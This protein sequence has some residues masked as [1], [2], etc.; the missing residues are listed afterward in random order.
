MVLTQLVRLFDRFDKINYRLRFYGTIDRCLSLNLGY[1]CNS[2][3]LLCRAFLRTFRICIAPSWRKWEDGRYSIFLSSSWVDVT[4]TTGPILLK[5][6]RATK[7]TVFW[8]CFRDFVGAQ[9]IEYLSES[10]HF[11]AEVF[12]I[13]SRFVLAKINFGGLVHLDS[14][15][16][17]NICWLFESQSI[18]LQSQCKFSSVVGK[19]RCKYFKCTVTLLSAPRLFLARHVVCLA[20]VSGRNLDSP[21]SSL[22]GSELKYSPVK[23]SFCTRRV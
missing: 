19:N 5:L 2:R 1:C 4:A 7:M 9:K 20:S 22:D 18:Q 3:S 13:T 6:G 15:K 8:S 17:M 23:S 21:Q 14:F 16:S 10:K 11:L 12:Q